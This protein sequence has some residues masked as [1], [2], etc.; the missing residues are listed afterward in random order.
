[1]SIYKAG[2]PWKFDPTT[3]AGHR[4]PNS[5]G[6]YRMRDGSGC[7]TYIGET[8]DLA[9]RMREHIRS[10]KL[11]TAQGCGSTLEYMVADGR[12]TSR[13]RREHEQ[14]SIE[15]H[16]PTLNRSKGGEGR[17]AGK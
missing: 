3:G 9:R 12:S 8:N 11:P 2:R 16:H 10:G 17:P 6:E 14:Q 15:K 7:I 1:M 13:T 4:P 5:P